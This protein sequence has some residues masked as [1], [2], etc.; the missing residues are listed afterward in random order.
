MGHGVG[1]WYMDS[2]LGEL[3]NTLVFGQFPFEY[4]IRGLIGKVY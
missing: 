3:K 2:T 1:T 4:L